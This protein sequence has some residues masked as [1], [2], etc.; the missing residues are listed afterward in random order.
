MRKYFAQFLA[1]L[2]VIVA[3]VIAITIGGCANYATKTLGGT[4]EIVLP[5]NTKLVNATWK[6][7]DFWYL[8]RPMRQGEVP[9]RYEFVEKSSLGT[10]NGK[11]TIIETK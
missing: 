5:P 3:I 8:V 2:V 1:L 9:E 4:M 11:V 10:M 7:D 6:E